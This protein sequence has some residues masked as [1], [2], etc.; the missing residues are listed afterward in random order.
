L[1][2]WVGYAGI[3]QNEAFSPRG[4]FLNLMV[5]TP[6]LDTDQKALE[7][8]LDETIYGTF[9]E[10]GA[11]Q[12]VARIFF[13][14]GAAAGTIAK[15]MSA[16]DKRYSDEIYGAEPSGRYV[17]AARLYKMLDHEYLLMEQRLQAHKPN[18]NFF[19]FADTV[20]AL[21]YQRTVAG[22]G[23]LGLRFQ[24]HPDARPNDLVLHVKMLD[25]D[26]QLQAASIGILG[27]NIVYA[28]Y[29]YADKPEVLVKSLIDGLRGRVVIDFISITGPDFMDLDNR[30]LSLLLVR[31][32]LTEVAMF[33][34]DGKNIHGSEFL[35]RKSLMVAR[36]HYRPPTL[37]SLDA[38]QASFAQFTSETDI[39]PS[40][41]HIM[42]ELTLENLQT[43]GQISKRDFLDRAHA[44]NRIGQWVIVSNCDN[45][46]RLINYLSDFKIHKLGLVIGVRELLDIITMKYYQNRDGNLLVAFGELFTRNIRIYGYPALA[47]DQERV[48]TASTMPVPEGI[49][50]LYKYLLES[51][52]IVEVNNYNES[53]LHIL[54]QNV[55]QM[56][57]EQSTGWEQ[58]LPAGLPEMIKE[59]GL[60]GWNAE[61]PV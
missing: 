53:L 58:Y 23:W 32:G 9:A 8:N 52:H 47:E 25:R 2:G 45:H 16:Y 21:D 4:V 38:I 46:Q 42:C 15:T 37:V 12:E 34:P 6:I 30:Y 1:F 54:P 3:E 35:Y 5:N 24:L 57:Q 17:C 18:T 29:R 41:A 28:C 48:L 26:T 43:N 55:L 33:G 27:V 19:V 56:I 20:A 59:E 14:V 31:E 44:L 51:Q 13:K 60:F 10:I 11:G 50:F 22:H 40:R 49:R 36:G 7:I 61:V 39:D